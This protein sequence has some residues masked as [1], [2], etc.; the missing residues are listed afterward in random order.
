MIRILLIED[1]QKTAYYI[2]KGL[3]ENNFNVALANDGDTALHMALQEQ[4]DIIITDIVLP[5]KDGW[6]IC[7]EIRSRKNE[8]P[9]LMLS[10]MSTTDDVVKG[11]DLGADDYLVKPF[12]FRELI[13][14]IKSLL[15]RTSGSKTSGVLTVGDLSLDVYSRTAV[16]AGKE[17][18]LTGKECALLEYIIKNQGRVIPR[19]EL[20]KN[21]WNID[22]DTGT[23]MVEVYV[24]YLRNK[25]DK[26]FEKKMIHTQFGLG[27]ILKADL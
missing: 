23:N 13:V 24:N 25:I 18:S 16:R 19:S 5:G 14:R 22:F 26:G 11:F 6:S 2:K 3:E 27:Y 7:K 12:E 10:A 4:F 17:I 21:V 8:V 1:E 15:K 9:I 20:A